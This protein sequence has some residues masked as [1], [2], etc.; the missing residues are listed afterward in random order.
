[1]PAK[2]ITITLPTEARKG[3]APKHSEALMVQMGQ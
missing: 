1:M 2:V 3:L